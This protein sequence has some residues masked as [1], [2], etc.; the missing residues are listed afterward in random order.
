[1]SILDKIPSL[2]KKKTG[3]K[4]VEELKEEMKQE[5]EQ[6][7]QEEAIKT[8]TTKTQGEPVKTLQELD[9]AEEAEEELTEKD[10]IPDELDEVDIDDDEVEVPD[11]ESEF[12]KPNQEQE[13][14]A[15][16]VVTPQKKQKTTEPAPTLEGEPTTPGY[17][18][19]SK[20]LLPNGL[21]QTTILSDIDFLD[22]KIGVRNEIV[23]EEPEQIQ[24]S[25]KKAE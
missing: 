22:E 7:K 16:P 3:D 6:Q 1:M 19:A 10:R 20:T 9:D 12:A 5:I 8:Q 2:A 4:P 15:N 23:L 24:P 11:E 14:I 18:V 25:Q 13:K 21:I 17:I